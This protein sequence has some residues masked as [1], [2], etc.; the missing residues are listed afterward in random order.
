MTKKTDLRVIKTKKA[1]KDAF[2]KLINE[3]NYNKIS[4][5]DIVNEALINRNTFYLHYLDK[6]DLLDQLTSSCLSR[7]DESMNSSAD[8]ESINDLSYDTLKQLNYN[9]F[10]AIEEDLELFQ[11]I[12]GNESVPYLSTK[13]NNTIRNHIGNTQAKKRKVYVEYIVAGFVGVI[14]LWLN[15]YDSYTIDEVSDLL[16]DIYSI[17][18]IDLLK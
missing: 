9:I 8:V 5:Q 1:I 10:R 11:V 4:V 18:M 14:K 16:V 12:L 7:L 13:L 2:L 6:D 15:N 3:K 17:D